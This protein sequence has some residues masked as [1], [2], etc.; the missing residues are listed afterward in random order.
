[1]SY[2]TQ[3]VVL[4]EKWES[5]QY[6]LI[7][8]NEIEEQIYIGD[9]SFLVTDLN[10]EPSKIDLDKLN[11]LLE[12]Y[13]ESHEEFDDWD[14]DHIEQFLEYAGYSSACVGS[15][16]RY[17]EVGTD[18]LLYNTETNEFDRSSSYVVVELYSWYN[19]SNYELIEKNDNTIEYK[20]LI[21]NDF[22]NLDEFDGNNFVTGGTGEHQR[23]YKIIEKDGEKTDDEYLLEYWSQ[24]QGKHA[25]GKILT[26]QGVIEH[27]KELEDRTVEEYM[28]EIGKLNSSV[29]IPLFGIK[30]FAEEI[31]WEQSRLSTKLKRQLEGQKVKYPLPEPLQ[32]L[33]ST[34]IWNSEQVMDYKGKIKNTSNSDL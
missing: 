22:V 16:P 17:L 4:W 19:G 34:P 20:L 2:F 6:Y 31:G 25:I 11:K 1:M 29:H 33:A 14:T 23:I 24:W 15:A 32:V 30:E 18:A 8:S 7:D 26:V 3:N 10:T 28:Y 5:G 13:K 27:I 9:G 21:T 12:D